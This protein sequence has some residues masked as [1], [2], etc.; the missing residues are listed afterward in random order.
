M[1][2][3]ARH[4]DERGRSAERPSDI[5]KKGWWDIAKRMKRDFSRFEL[6]V[7]SAG[8]A[9]NEFF[10]LF[11][12]ILAGVSLYGLVAE[13]ETVERQMEAMSSFLPSE[14]QGFLGGQLHAV[15]SAP[16]SGLGLSLAI[17]VLIALW[18]ATKGVKALIA[19][20]NIVH[21]EEEKRGFVAYT[22]TSL[23]LTL[24]AI[25]FGLL[26]LTLVAAL[27]PIL[28]LLPIG[29]LGRT[30]ASALRWPLL[31]V[32]V[33]LGLAIIYR[34]GPSRE[35]PRWR[36]VS[37]GA[38]LAAVLWLGGSALFSL[39]ASRFGKFNET[40]GS[41]AAVMVTLLWFQLTAVSVLLGALLDAEME[42]QTARDT[43]TGPERPMG[44]RGARVADTVRPHGG[45]S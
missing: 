6:D 45:R 23:G 34:Y 13:P 39:Y 12:A 28:N 17:A 11:P 29:D 4:G 1:A 3:S 2:S 5:P 31:A 30:L 10:A 42:Q 15:A 9:F 43:T 25:L 41:L 44:E 21:Q 20:L 33:L 26:A 24:G 7:V 22:L 37:W 38:V 36:W 35:R 18:G 32:F 40:Y 16:S 8:V 19:G 14:V 27:P